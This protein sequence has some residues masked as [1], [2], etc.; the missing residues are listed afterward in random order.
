M[1]IRVNNFFI[2][3]LIPA[4]LLSMIGLFSLIPKP[5]QRERTDNGVG[6]PGDFFNQSM[7]VNDDDFQSG[8]HRLDQPACAIQNFNP[9]PGPRYNVSFPFNLTGPDGVIAMCQL[10]CSTLAQLNETLWQIPSLKYAETPTLSHENN[11][12]GDA[13][14]ALSIVFGVIGG[15]FL[16]LLMVGSFCHAAETGRCEDIYGSTEF[17]ICE[18]DPEPQANPNTQPLLAATPAH[19]PL[20]LQMTSQSGDF[21]PSGKTGVGAPLPAPQDAFTFR[22]LDPSNPNVFED[23]HGNRYIGILIDDA[24][25]SGGGNAG[26]ADADNAEHPEDSDSDSEGYEAI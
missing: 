19:A 26:A 4:A 16:C 3:L 21:D 23:A 24:A 7:M 10:A 8:R 18:R 9:F 14:M 5:W 25:T 17:E 12:K 22:A 13:F 6:C 11:G 1:R 20:Q 15:G 2:L